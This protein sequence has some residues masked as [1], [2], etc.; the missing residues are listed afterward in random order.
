M[1]RMMKSIALAAVLVVTLTV[2][3]FALDL[4]TAKGQG[5]VGE[6][7]DGY[8]GAVAAGRAD[9]QALVNDINAQRRAKYQGIA[10]RRGTTLAAVEQFVGQKLISRAD[11]GEYVMTPGGQWVRK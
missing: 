7:P 3:A 11:P 5:L 6:R 9:V 4:G 2:N 8:L 1:K 10:E